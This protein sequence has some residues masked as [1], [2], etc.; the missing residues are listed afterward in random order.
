M[1]KLNC[2]KTIQGLQDDLDFHLCYFVQLQIWKLMEDDPLFH[3]STSTPS[4]D[5]FQR[6]TTLRNKKIHSYQI[7]SNEEMMNNPKKVILVLSYED[8]SISNAS[9]FFFSFTFQENS[10]TIT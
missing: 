5:E 9:Y 1:N 8:Q 2:K 4:I 3:H 6:L 7:L 10:N